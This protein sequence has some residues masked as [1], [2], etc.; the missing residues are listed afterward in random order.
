MIELDESLL[1]GM[2]NEREC[3]RHPDRSDV[4]IK[5]NRAGIRGR[6]Q[7][8][9]EFRYF[10]Y[11]TGRKIPFDHLPLCHGWCE[12]NR[13]RGL[14]FEMVTDDDNA[15]SRCLVDQVR[16]GDM[17]EDQM[18]QEL[19]DLHD[20][21]WRH[22]LV[23]GDINVD[24]MLYQRRESGNR[25]M[26]IDG[27]GGRRPGFK[28]TLLRYVRPLARRKMRKNWPRILEDHRKALSPSKDSSS[29]DP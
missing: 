20:Y 24:Q 5:V 11:L 22:S 4:C 8:I 21:L 14:L 13:G 17:T 7:N 29:D 10:G 26:I 15:I 2:G 25:L 28:A 19:S 27:M 23:I 9:L 18:W 6:R 16:A 3:Y 1:L 12:T